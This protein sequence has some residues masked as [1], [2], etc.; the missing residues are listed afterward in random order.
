MIEL[1]DLQQT[2]HAFAACNDDDEVWN[3]FGWVMASDEDLLAARLWL[4]SSS[5]G[6]LDDDGERSAAL[7][8]MGLFPYL[9]P[10][11]FADVL[12]VQKRQRPLSSLQDYAQALAYYAEYDAFQQ[13][14]GIDE[15]LVEAGAA[16]Q[17]AARGAGVG[18]G[19]FASFDLMLRV[20]PEGQI[21]AAAQRVA[22]LLEIPMG[23]ALARCRALPLL[24]GQALD[25]NRAQ[26]IKDEFEAIG[27][28]VQ[29]YGFK[30]FPWMDA[31]V[32]R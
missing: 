29:V 19:I 15:A 30:P 24:L 22:R 3:A 12:D 20:C 17:A 14:E 27:A 10:A 25:R 21:K 7:A 32:L 26:A 9:E 5:D 2:L 16:E 28:T 1:L 13:V 6:V 11:T 8:A 23:E 18:T 31:P 4:P